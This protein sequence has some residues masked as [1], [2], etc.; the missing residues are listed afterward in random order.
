MDRVSS[1]VSMLRATSI[2]PAIPSQEM[3]ANLRFRNREPSRHWDEKTRLMPA[4]RAEIAP[5]LRHCRPNR[6]RLLSPP[7][8]DQVPYLSLRKPFPSHPCR[9]AV[10]RDI[11]RPASAAAAL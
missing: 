9:D 7:R 2:P 10:P 8:V 11:G 3:P 6:Q 1:R 5:P 4:L